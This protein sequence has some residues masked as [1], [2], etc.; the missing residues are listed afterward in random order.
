MPPAMPFERVY[1]QTTGAE[2][3]ANE[4]SPSQSL[5]FVLFMLPF[6]ERPAT[7]TTSP[8]VARTTSAMRWK[9]NVSGKSVR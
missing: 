2:M 1:P 8:A 7:S 3:S 4:I 6:H 5:T 9:S